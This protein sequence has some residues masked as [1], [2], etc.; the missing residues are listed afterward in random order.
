MFDF[1]QKKSQANSQN[2]YV[3][4]RIIFFIKKE[5]NYLLRQL[6]S[7]CLMFNIILLMRFI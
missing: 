2:K 4:V 6:H 5:C 7:M 1:L 3:S